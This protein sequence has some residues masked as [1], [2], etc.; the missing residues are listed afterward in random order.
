MMWRVRSTIAAIVLLAL[1]AC[2][3]SAESLPSA[4]RSAATI[5]RPPAMAAWHY[6]L[7]GDVALGTATVLDVDGFDTPASFVAEARKVGRY[8]V[9]YI[10]AGT[11][12]DWRPDQ[13]RFP[14][15]VLGNRNGWPGERWLDIRRLD[16][17]APIMRARMRICRDKRFRAVE[18]DNVDGY[19]NNTGFP[20]TATHQLVYNRWLARTAHQLGLAVALKNDLDQARVLATRFD[21]AV[22]EQCFE[23]DECDKSRPFTRAGKA[24]FDAEYSLTRD[25]FCSRA[26]AL[27]ISGLQADTDLSGPTQPC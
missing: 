11:W 15:S 23:Y 7:Q 2:G 3:A 12:E 1:S 19:T 13:A 17:L 20:L 18:P 22:V 9:C 24:V 21:F 26:R 8:P 10:D 16:V 6:Q 27:G 14:S 5:R 4:E 25:Q